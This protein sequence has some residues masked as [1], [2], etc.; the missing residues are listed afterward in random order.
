LKGES[1]RARVN[2]RE[3]RGG[4]E[5]EGRKGASR[6]EKGA[7]QKET[8]EE[9]EKLLWYRLRPVPSNHCGWGELM[10]PEGIQEPQRQQWVARRMAMLM[11]LH[12]KPQITE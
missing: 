8:Q 5:E 6:R 7:S 10:Q 11:Q 3:G 4:S 1:S 2:G 12:I 9:K